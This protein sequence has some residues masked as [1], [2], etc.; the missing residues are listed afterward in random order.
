MVPVE[1]GRTKGGW[2]VPIELDLLLTDTTEVGEHIRSWRG[3]SAFSSC[4]PQLVGWPSRCPQSLK[5]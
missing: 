2:D 5:S 3:L 1:F 4:L